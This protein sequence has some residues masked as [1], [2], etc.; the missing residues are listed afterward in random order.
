[1]NKDIEINNKTKSEIEKLVSELNEHAYNYYTLDEPTIADKEYDKLYQKLEKLEK[2][3]GYLMPES[4]TQRVGDKVLEKFEKHEHIGRLYS[5]GKAQTTGELLAWDTRARKLISEYNSKCDESKKLPEI[6]YILEMKFDGLTVNLT[7]ENGLLVM[8]TTR[9]NGIVGEVITPQIKTIK[10][11]PM[12][13]DYKEKLE[14]QGEGV[15]PLSSLEK[16]NLI[17]DEPLKNARNA[18]AGALR[19][20]DSK[21]TATRNLAA[22]MYNIGYLEEDENLKS[23][24]DKKFKTHLEMIDFLRKNKLPVF[25]Y[26][27][28]YER[29]EDIIARIDEI[30]VERKKFDV[31]T[32]GLVIKINDMRTR[33][34]LGSTEK[35]PRWAVA[36]KFEAEE[37]TTVLKNVEWNVGRTGKITPTAVFEAVDIGG[38]KIERATLN[39]YEDI[40]RKKVK[41]N[42]TIWI[43]RS[44]DV[45]PEIMGTVPS[46]D[47]NEIEIVMPKNCPSCGQPL[48][49]NGVHYFCINSMSCKPQLVSRITHFASRNAMNIEGF[50]EKTAEQ[51]FDKLGL[52]DLPSLYEL[53]YEDLIGLDK[54]AEKKTNKLLENIEMS[55][56]CKLGNFLYAIGIPRI[57]AKTASDLANHFESL[58]RIRNSTFE[59]LLLI[60]DIGEILAEEIIQYFKDVETVKNLDKF[61][62]L[63][64]NPTHKAINVESNDKLTGKTFVLTGTLTIPR[65]EAKN[66]IEKVGGKVTSAISKKTDYLLAGRDAGSKLGKAE[67]LGVEILDEEKFRFL[68]DN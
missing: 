39:N 32:D 18:A 52:K 15:M 27:K 34:V 5:L 38:A 12:R 24:E 3:T 60:P 31:L 26:V 47:E 35:F 10:N 62:S 61:L 25:D 67:K 59:E 21:V 13:I 29:I 63:G 45:I 7:Y 58:D 49:K 1:M 36:Y 37:F 51:L 28:K 41:I 68:L 43:R 65:S 20:L 57:G 9:G 23:D 64:V 30:N 40:L 8:G 17:S 55:K 44:N 66:M 22:W 16:Y 42:S 53:K 33:E 2:E 46:N 11:I 19:N 54:F 56:N 48:V 6:E 14:I 50:S 4:P